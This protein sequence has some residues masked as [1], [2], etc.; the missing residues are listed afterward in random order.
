MK[1][2]DYKYNRLKYPNSGKLMTLH[3]MIV[4]HSSTLKSSATLKNDVFENG[5]PEK[6]LLEKSLSENSMNGDNSNMSDVTNITS[7]SNDKKTNIQHIPASQAIDSQAAAPVLKQAAPHSR[8]GFLGQ[9]TAIGAGIGVSMLPSAANAQLFWFGKKETDKPKN[10]ANSQN[11]YH[12]NRTN[13]N[14]AYS[15]YTPPT[16]SDPYQLNNGQYPTDSQYHELYQQNPIEY[17]PVCATESIDTRLFSSSNASY[18]ER[19]DMAL[20]RMQCAGFSIK[21]PEILSRSY[22]RFAGTDQQRA[23]DLQQVA[24]GRVTAPELMLGVRGGYGAMRI[25]DKVSWDRLGRVMRERGTILAG[26]SDVTAIQSALYA[27]GKMSSLNAPMFY[28]EFG[29]TTPDEISCS[30]FVKALTSKNLSLTTLSSHVTSSKLPTILSK[31]PYKKRAGVI[32]GGNLSVLSAISGTSFLPKPRGGIVFIEEVGEQPYR[33][34]RMLYDMY[35]TGAFK[36]QQAI[37]FGA[38]ARMGSD[39]YHNGYD[40]AEVVRHLHRLTGLPIYSGLGFGHIGKKQSFPMGCQCLIIP[41]TLGGFDL[42]FSGYP[43]IDAKRI[44]PEALTMPLG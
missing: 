18:A 14:A 40:A 42:R 36:G 44:Q 16:S 39:S 25:L 33:I 21:N 43:T 27:K 22:F 37:V 32:W 6:S 9:L 7:L 1:L 3:N 31:T 26:F 10:Y 20:T 8:R 12:T 2:T 24:T 5:T 23:S 28:S 29:K 11:N 19:G 38:L 41:N 17:R 13:S 15:R 30:G 4:D 34:E 35:L